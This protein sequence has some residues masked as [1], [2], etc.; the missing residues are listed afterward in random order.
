MKCD[1]S[2]V[3]KMAWGFYENC[4]NLDNFE[5]VSGYYKSVTF[6]LCLKEAWGREKD[7]VE[8]VNREEE[9]APKSDQFKAWNWAERKLGVR[10]DYTPV[11]KMRFVDDVVQE[12]GYCKSVWFCGIKAVEREI[13]LAKREP[14]NFKMEVVA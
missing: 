6:D 11:D 8:S 14:E 12:W 5:Y 1:K 3:M 9:R 7:F 2:R 13:E 10:F 4:N